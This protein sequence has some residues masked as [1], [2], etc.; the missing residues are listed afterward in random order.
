MLQ[1]FEG[2]R[3]DI[4]EELEGLEGILDADFNVTF[5]SFKKALQKA[6]I[7]VEYTYLLK[8][9]RGQCIH[10]ELCELLLS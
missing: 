4:E 2:K 1:I 9:L 6:D 3:K 7:D 10:D 5:D 8:G